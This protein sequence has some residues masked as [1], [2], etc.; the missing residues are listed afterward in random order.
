MTKVLC[1]VDEAHN[2]EVRYWTCCCEVSDYLKAAFLRRYQI[3]KKYRALKDLILRK[4]LKQLLTR[5]LITRKYLIQQLHCK[6]SVPKIRH[7]YVQKRN[8]AAIVPIHV[9]VS[10]LFIPMTHE[11]GNWD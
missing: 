3:A 11:C 8:C 1:A 2:P 6:E 4:Y 9:S 5:N 7:K 10:D